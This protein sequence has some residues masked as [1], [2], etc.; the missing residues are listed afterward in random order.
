MKNIKQFDM[1]I[2][3]KDKT[4][5]YKKAETIVK[6]GTLGYVTDIIHNDNLPTGYIV[7]LVE[8]HIKTPVFVF[9]ENEID[10]YQAKPN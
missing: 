2:V 5:E 4:F 8:T 3:L 10:F 6:K 7:E 1:V 9:Y